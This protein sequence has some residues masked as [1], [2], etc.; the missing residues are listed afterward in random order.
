[1]EHRIIEGELRSAKGA[2]ES[3]VGVGFDPNWSL[4]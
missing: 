1:M 4:K 2:V 3:M